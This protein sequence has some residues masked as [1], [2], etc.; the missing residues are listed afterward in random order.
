LIE[1]GKWDEV[2]ALLADFDF[3]ETKIRAFSVYELETDY[4]AALAQ[5]E[6]DKQGKEILQAFEEH[7]C[8][9]VHHIH[10]APEL[11]FP[12]LYN[13]LTWLDAPDGPL[14]VLCERAR[15]RHTGWLRSVQDPRLALSPSTSSSLAGHTDSVNAVAV[16][17]DGKYVV[18]G[19]SDRTVKIWEL[20]NGRLAHTFE[21]H[22]REV[23]GVVAS[24]DRKHVV[25]KS[26]DETVKVWELDSGRCVS[27]ENVGFSAK[28]VTPDGKYVIGGKK[29]RMKDDRTVWVWEQGSGKLAYPLAGYEGPKGYG[30]MDAIIYEIAVTPDGT[31]MVAWSDTAPEYEYNR[32][33]NVWE[34]K[35]GGLVDTL[36]SHT[37]D[38]NAVVLSPD[39]KYVVSG[40]D[41]QT[42]KVWEMPTGSSQKLFGNDAPIISIA[43]SPDDHWLVCGDAVGRV[44]I[45]EWMNANLGPPIVTPW[46]RDEKLAFGCPFCLT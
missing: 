13:H 6:G 24:P 39:G 22:T 12:Q 21:G 28:A 23:I 3:M 26:E 45:F 25:S 19:S 10:S 11:L 35:S 32:A 38:V 18:S 1:A 9:D 46:S 33:I 40:S 42:V 4:R 29:Y 17:P 27:S 30:C 37:G 14:H 34:L 43:L 36:E 16:T 5:W 41:D 2:E 7:L 8:L 20:E 44:W 31:Y 15:E